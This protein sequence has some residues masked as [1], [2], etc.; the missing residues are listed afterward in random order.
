MDKKRRKCFSGQQDGT[1][2]TTLKSINAIVRDI[3]KGQRSLTN[4]SLAG[5]CYAVPN[6]H[7]DVGQPCFLSAYADACLK[8]ADLFY[9][10]IRSPFAIRYY[11]DIDIYSQEDVAA[12][13]VSIGECVHRTVRKFYAD[14]VEDWF[15]CA[16]SSAPPSA[17][18][19][20]EEG[21]VLQVEA[22]HVLVGRTG[23]RL[24]RAPRDGEGGG[25]ASLRVSREHV[26]SV[27]AG[28]T[29]LTIEGVAFYAC[30]QKHGIHINF[31]DLL[32]SDRQAMTMREAVVVELEHDTALSGL[33]CNGWNDAI[34]MAVYTTSGLRM[35]GSK[36]LADCKGCIG[37]ACE[38][39]GGE[40]RVCIDR[41]Y[42]IDFVLDKHGNVS[43]LMTRRMKNSFHLAV[44]FCSIRVA[45]P[46][47]T[48]RE[49]WSKPEQYPDPP[50][51]VMTKGGPKVKADRK[52]PCNLVEI[53]SPPMREEAQ[54]IL[55]CRVSSHYEDLTVTKL[56]AKDPHAP[57]CIYVHVDGRNKRY[58]LNKCGFHK[59]NVIFFRIWLD[60][61]SGKAFIEQR[62]R[63]QNPTTL[64]RVCG[65]CRAWRSASRR[66]TPASK[67]IFFS[68]VS[69]HS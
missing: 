19:A 2:K 1:L 13:S 17:A 30:V 65:Q 55:R 53:R 67:R 34:D 23:Y 39:C 10:E 44:Q 16:V 46:N 15:V 47:P 66:L 5:G 50:D 40:G 63:S 24:K 59:R 61:R 33:P 20:V 32:V 51:V 18:C 26:A 14:P 35:I 56:V 45:S 64:G 22:S 49:G 38:E 36:K 12:A 3:D 54:R 42:S 28:E 6:A 21:D 41:A 29:V 57:Q 48:P 7:Y 60:A 52:E 68:R 11:L 69:P 62:C 58:C 25:V 43:D 4:V 31:H 27:A 9:S 8:G 37:D